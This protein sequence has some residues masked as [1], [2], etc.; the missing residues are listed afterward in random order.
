MISMWE[1]KVN[2][3]ED[4]DE[5]EKKLCEIMFGEKG[6]CSLLNSMEYK[7]FRLKCLYGVDYGITR[8]E[9]DNV[10]V[11]WD[12]GYVQIFYNYQHEYNENEDN[13]RKK[14]CYMEE[15]DILPSL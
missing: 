5:V 12:D 1:Y 14:R 9:R 6:R 8:I 10:R 15:E 7:K 11:V 2:K 3:E 4:M 13:N